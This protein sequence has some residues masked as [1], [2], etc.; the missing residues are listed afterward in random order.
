MTRKDSTEVHK[1][2]ADI[3]KDTGKAILVIQLDKDNKR[4]GES[5]WLPLSQV[6]SM[7]HYDE[8]SEVVVKAWLAREK[9]II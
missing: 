1:F 3:I 4:I 6:K 2:K 7:H 5:M 9:G 8:Y